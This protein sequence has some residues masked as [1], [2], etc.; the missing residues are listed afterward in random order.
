MNHD[1]V[2]S[3]RYLITYII[4]VV[5]IS[6]TIIIIY[7]IYVYLP[8]ANTTR[9]ALKVAD[10]V[11][12]TLKAGCDIIVTNASSSGDNLIKSIFPSESRGVGNCREI[13]AS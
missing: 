6:L 12:L 2:P 4:I 13:L 9:R 7:Y 11:N 5:I 10:D 3:K 1:D 8:L